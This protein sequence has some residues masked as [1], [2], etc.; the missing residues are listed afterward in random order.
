MGR[1]I[2]PC[3]FCLALLCTTASAQYLNVAFTADNIVSAWYQNGSDPIELT[4]QALPNLDDWRVATETQVN[5]GGWGHYRLIFEVQNEGVGTSGNP[6]GFL[7]EV[8]GPGVSGDLLS[9]GIPTGSGNPLQESMWEW[10]PK[11]GET[12][13][14]PDFGSMDWNTATSYGTNGDNDIWNSN[15]G[16]V[17]GISLDAEWIWNG[18]NYQWEQGAPIYVRGDFHVVPEP[19]TLAILGLS[20]ALFG[21]ARLRRR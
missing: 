12:E 13:G 8:S 2:V 20:L 3:I 11:P 15:G 6:A 5:L 16:P 9:Q 4:D 17:E 21:V 19:A 10:A 18:D 1:L 7:A 14:G